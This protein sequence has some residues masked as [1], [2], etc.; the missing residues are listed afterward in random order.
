MEITHILKLAVKK[1][2]RG[3]QETPGLASVQ[4]SKAFNWR[5]KKE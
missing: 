2:N 4:T 1:G 3:T 5:E